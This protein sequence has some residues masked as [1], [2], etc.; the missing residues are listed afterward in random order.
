LD[1]DNPKYQASRSTVWDRIEFPQVSHQKRSD[2]F[3][4]AKAGTIT[5]QNA[6]YPT[7]SVIKRYVTFYFTNVPDMVPYYIVKE[8]FEASGILDN[9]FLSRKRNKQGQIYGFVRYV[10]VRDVEKMLKGLNHISFGQ[11][12]VWAKVARFGRHPLE[13]VKPSVSE[14]V[15]G[16]AVR[17]K[18]ENIDVRKIMTKGGKNVGEGGK[19]ESGAVNSIDKVR[20]EVRLGKATVKEGGGQGGGVDGGRPREAG[21]EFSQQFSAAK[22]AGAVQTK[23]HFPKP[24]GKLIRTYKSTTYDLSW[25]SKG[26]VASVLYGE[27]ISV[28]QNHIADA[29]F[30]DIDI[31]P[32]GADKVFIRCVSNWDVMKTFT[33]ADRILASV[34]N[35]IEV[36][37][38]SFPQGLVS[39]SRRQ[40]RY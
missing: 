23:Q 37:K 18:E 2:E 14:V 24:V 28:I 12:C 21:G 31:I 19:N 5:W 27:S 16:E 39:I 17:K 8:S 15:R 33:E 7:G 34:L 10:N 38:I 30:E 36:V 22:R 3:Q 25:A 20:E 11:Y 29:G 13:V 6:T 1:Q 35:T 4:E 26:V 32:L 9:L 40:L